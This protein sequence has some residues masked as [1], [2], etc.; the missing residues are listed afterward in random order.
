MSVPV[1]ENVYD[2]IVIGMA[3][4]F[5]GRGAGQVLVCCA[6]PRTEIVLDL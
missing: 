5:V 1:T 6:Q 2:V 4:A 3:S